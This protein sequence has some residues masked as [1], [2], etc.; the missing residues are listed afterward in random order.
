MPHHFFLSCKTETPHPLNTNFPSPAPLG[1][2]NPL[3][4]TTPGTSEK[5]NDR[6]LLK[7]DLWMLLTSPACPYTAL[8]LSIFHS[9]H[10]DENLWGL[11]D[12]GNRWAGNPVL[13]ETPSWFWVA[14]QEKSPRDLL[15]IL[16][17][18]T[19]ISRQHCNC[20]L[21][22]VGGEPSFMGTRFW[23]ENRCGKT[24]LANDST[25]PSCFTFGDFRLGCWD[26]QTWVSFIF[27]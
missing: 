2:G 1:P 23:N 17:G 14:T 12:H 22:V 21:G 4:L 10:D 25:L 9:L 11:S 13:V 26:R 20:G 3:T 16:S 5:L 18:E 8:P 7:N 24:W 19:F 6:H 27:P 15:P